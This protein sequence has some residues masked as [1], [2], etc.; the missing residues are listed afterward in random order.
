MQNM[1][2]ISLLTEIMNLPVI[3]SPGPRPEA[4]ATLRRQA[5]SQSISR[6]NLNRD[7]RPGGRVTVVITVR[8]PP[9]NM[10]YMIPTIINGDI[11]VIKKF[12]TST[13]GPVA[14]HLHPIMATRHGHVGFWHL[15]PS[16]DKELDIAAQNAEKNRLLSGGSVCDTDSKT[17]M[18]K[19][20]IKFADEKSNRATPTRFPSAGKGNMPVKQVSNHGCIKSPSLSPR[21]GNHKFVSITALVLTYSADKAVERSCSDENRQNVFFTFTLDGT[22][23]SEWTGALFS[24][25][26][27]AEV[28]RQRGNVRSLEPC[29]LI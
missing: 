9:V 17:N 13:A 28:Q 2:N 20:R 3:L 29:F 15:V 27:P 8:L 19:S 23:L 16:I 11:E 21:P 7:R 25:I 4:T 1:Q 24:S 10:N 22:V 18:H 14:P 26:F 12:L 6:P 5:Q